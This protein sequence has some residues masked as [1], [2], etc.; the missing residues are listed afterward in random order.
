M[1][2]GDRQRVVISRVLCL[3]VLLVAC[4]GTAQQWIED[5][6]ED[7]SD[8]RLDAA[9]Q[10]LYVSRDGKVRT[11]HRF[12]LNNDGWL[13]L[14]FNSTHDEYAFIP[15]SLVT[16]SRDGKRDVRQSP[17]V[18]E[19]SK[20]VA[21]ADLNRDGRLDL[22][23]CPN[24]SGVQNSRRF[25]TIIY[26]GP[27]G[28]AARRSNGILPVRGAETIAVADLNRD[29]WPDVVVLN[30]EAWLRDQPSGRIVRVYWGGE[31]G[32]LLSRRQD[33]GVPGAV[34]LSAGDFDGDGTVDLAV[35]TGD[36]HVRVFWATPT[37]KTTT[38][39]GT[40][41]IALPAPGGVCITGGD[42]DGD[43]RADLVVGTSRETVLIVRSEG[44]RQWAQPISVPAFGASHVAVGDID[45]DK[46]PEIVLTKMSLALA[47]G[48]EVTG[49]DK[50]APELVHI[51]WGDK[52]GFSKSRV[53]SVPVRNAS[54]TAI[55]DLD[56]DGRA[57]LV[58]AVYQGA[59][60]FAAESLVFFGQGE[61]GL[62]RGPQGVRTEGATRVA[63]APGEDT[64]P[65][66]A[67]FCNSRGGMLGENVPLMVYWGGAD[68][69]DAKRRW[70]I[71]FASG[72]ESSAADLNADGF[73]DLIAMNSGHGGREGTAGALGANIF[74]GGADGF[75]IRKRVTSLP[76]YGL[77]ASNVADLN[78][79]G[80]LDL[81]LCKFAADDAGKTEELIV[82]YG[83]GGG[84]DASRRTVLDS[85]GRSGGAAIADF[86]RDGWLDIASTS[87]EADRVRVFWGGAAGFD[88]A[89][90]SGVDAPSPIGLET[91]DLNSDGWLDLIVGSYCD[92]L[93]HHQDT[94]VIIFWGGAEGFRAWDA[95]R[96][97]G[98]TPVGMIVADWDADGYLDLFCPHYHGE[99]T[100][101]S[102]PCYLYWGG[103]DGFAPRRR[104][105]LVCDSAD[106]GLAG[107][108]D[109]DGKLD[110][111]VVCHTVDG[112]HNALS[113][114][115]YNDGKR[116][117][118]PRVQYLPTH[119]AHW[120]W[121]QDMG[122]IYDRTF[123]QRYESS[124]FRCDGAA[125]GGKLVYKA[126]VPDGAR[127]S[128]KVRSAGDEKALANAAWRDV[129]SGG[130]T[131]KAGDRCL[132]YRA[133]FV[134]ENGDRYPVLDRVGV[135]VLSD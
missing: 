115:F 10:N 34:D 62:V 134:S 5:S 35:L 133:T 3:L 116:F 110:L 38:Q 72:Y 121:L 49:A 31:E 40:T 25:V 65:A 94:G 6:F 111:A 98:W 33:I 21:V 70:L 64:Q 27:D 23:F 52:D 124:V 19:G 48:G 119:G 8:G 44:S 80:W 9:G 71:P 24:F 103:A 75:D 78:K 28:W 67:I 130:F 55:G 105:I 37:T 54:S 131:L 109:K 63:I 91:A 20:A 90:Q 128:F 99:L 46:R 1:S 89:K 17:L 14:I 4:P 81:V 93:A 132:Q 59:E 135:R 12:D 104:T 83:S 36:G 73:V 39:L 68:G 76:H 15:A 57:D 127:L 26:G 58:V 113:R 50:G 53:T 30:E 106:D 117:E 102:M 85:P 92:K 13:D 126:E 79:D 122:H 82:Y 95:Q 84:F 16:V 77:W 7:F 129:E 108:F 123:R 18:V 60:T 86:N 66:R 43:G 29:A 96:L 74:W 100:R 88:S 107:D 45:G 2:T 114:V 87:Y 56:G 61:R 101:E 41:D 112:N 125:R 118:G 42:C 22:A 32:Y 11:I 51:L 69:F 97:P 47:A 120:M